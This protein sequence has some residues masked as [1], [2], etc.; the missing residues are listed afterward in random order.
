MD[1]LCN[2]DKIRTGKIFYFL[3]KFF[4]SLTFVM[5][6]NSGS[7]LCTEN[8]PNV[9]ARLIKDNYSTPWPS[10]TYHRLMGGGPNSSQS[11]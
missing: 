8:N 7:G 2:K 1:V 3:I 10:T 5:K 4:F 6:I 11:L 9:A